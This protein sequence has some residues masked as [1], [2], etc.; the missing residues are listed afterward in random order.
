MLKAVMD[1]ERRINPAAFHYIS[2]N[3]HVIEQVKAGHLHGI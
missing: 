3:L 2:R 1:L